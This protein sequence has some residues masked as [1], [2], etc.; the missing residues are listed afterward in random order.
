MSFHFIEGKPDEKVSYKKLEEI[1]DKRE[2]LNKTFSTKLSE[3][4]SIYGL[5]DLLR[6][7]SYIAV[8]LAAC[9]YIG[10]F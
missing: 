2:E 9:K 7:S 6:T 4:F 8:T 3:L 5:D 1:L 10:V